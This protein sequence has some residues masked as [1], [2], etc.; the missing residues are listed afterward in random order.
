MIDIPAGQTYTEGFLDC[1]IYGEPIFTSSR[2]ELTVQ[3]TPLIF[4]V[5][6][7]GVWLGQDGSGT[8]NILLVSPDGTVTIIYAGLAFE[9]H[10]TLSN[11]GT[12]L[13][14]SFRQDDPGPDGELG[15]FSS[16]ASGGILQALYVPK[17]QPYLNSKNTPTKPW[18]DFFDRIARFIGQPV[19][20]A[21]VGGILDPANGGT[22]N[23]SG[24]GQASAPIDAEY[25]V[26]AA[27]AM[28]T[29]ERVATDTP[30][31]VWNFATAGQAK[32]TVVAYWIPLVDG[33]E[34]PVFI[35]DGA[36]HLILVAVNP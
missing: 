28:L 17:S 21:Q 19:N 30:S 27:N 13:Y 31:I 18:L 10:L 32:A 36:G 11:D 16:S 25:I 22:G 29:A 4:P 24:G 8:D 15:Q 2:R 6:R 3:G 14:I 9:P 23:N 33:S 35:T 5:E 1:T 7:N 12:T 20:L 34:P 26:A